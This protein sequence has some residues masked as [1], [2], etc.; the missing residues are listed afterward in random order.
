MQK[1]MTFAEP[2]AKSVADFRRP[3]TMRAGRELD[4]VIAQQVMEHSLT[5]QKREVYEGTPKGTRPLAS[6]STD[7][8]AAWEVVEKL[9]ITLVPI[10]NGSWFAL[11]GNGARWRSPADLIQYLQT[12]NFVQAGAAVGTDPALVVCLAAVK[13]IENRDSRAQNPTDPEASPNTTH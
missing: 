13:A 12:G 7:I 9:A 3:K 1:V 4:K 10:E 6:Y 11:V 5:Q 8:S 2:W